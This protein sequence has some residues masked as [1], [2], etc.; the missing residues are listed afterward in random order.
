[1]IEMLCENA[2]IPLPKEQLLALGRFAELVE[3][4]NKVLNLTSIRDPR[5]FMIKQV[6]NSLYFRKFV[7]LR[8]GSLVADLGT[9]GGFPGLPL[10]ITHPESHFWLVDSVQKKVKAVEEFAHQLGL[11]NVKTSSE[12]LETLGHYSEYRGRFDVV[13]AQA[14]A[15]LP[16]LLELATPLVKT[17]GLFV[18]FKGPNYVEELAQSRRAMAEL[19]LHAP[20]I[21]SY[22]LPDNMGERFLLI[23][24]KTNGTP[25]KYPRGIG[26]PNKHP[27]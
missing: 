11:G 16:V 23:F 22:S 12:R 14:L 13:T 18:A 3:A 2:G 1:M 5:E 7:P 21:E 19:K 8:A 4:K 20:I 6:L 26:V 17:E 9:G 27:L 10:A 24:K 15:P 25:L